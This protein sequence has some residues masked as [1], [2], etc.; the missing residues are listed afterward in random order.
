MKKLLLALLLVF[1]VLVIILA[2][3]TSAFKSKQIAPA[4]GKRIEL[5]ID[6]AA[7]KHLSDAIR[8]NTVSEDDTALVN[9]AAFDSFFTFLKTEYAPVFENTEDTIINKRSLLLKWKGKNETSKPVIL[10]AHLDV[11]PI[12]E[13]TKA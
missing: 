7:V 3:K 8:I 13:S 5:P 11:V 4:D 9:Q 10:Y 2:V 12:E 6:E 1:I